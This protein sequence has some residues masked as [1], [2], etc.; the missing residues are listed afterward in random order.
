MGR[1]SVM[2]AGLLCAGCAV[3]GAPV[4]I[5]A[6]REEP[7]EFSGQLVSTCG[8]F[9]AAFEVCSLAE[10]KYHF[11]PAVWVSPR[12]DVCLPQRAILN[13]KS[14]FARVTG[15][16]HF[17]ASYG[18]LGLYPIALSEASVLPVN[19]CAEGAP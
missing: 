7:S 11:S 15:R 17:G 9:E 5:E 19:S 16:V 13:P 2:F 4:A 12:S 18:H 10:S 3:R 6:L 14:F 8:W 1:I